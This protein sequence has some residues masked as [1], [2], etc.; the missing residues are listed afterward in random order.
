MMMGSSAEPTGVEAGVPDFAGTVGY[1]KERIGSGTSSMPGL[2][3]DE[4]CDNPVIEDEGV[5]CLVSGVFRRHEACTQEGTA[6][7]FGAEV[8]SQGTFQ[9]GP[10]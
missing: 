4:L 9:G 7:R 3:R 2:K 10:P 5:R 6:W 1:G 8:L